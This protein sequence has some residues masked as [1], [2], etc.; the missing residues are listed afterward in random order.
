MNALGSTPNPRLIG[1]LPVE[2]MPITFDIRESEMFLEGKQ[3]GL[4]EG[5][6]EGLLEGM[7][8]ALEIKYGA[9]GLELMELVKKV[10]T[11]EKLNRLKVLI[12]R[13]DTIDEVRA[14]LIGM[15]R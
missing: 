6:R 14:N 9:M 13:S 3:E 10:D 5:K 1:V 7:E 12:K 4:L 2:N 15:L 8:M 11:L